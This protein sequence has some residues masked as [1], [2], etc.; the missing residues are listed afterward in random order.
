MSRRNPRPLV[1]RVVEAAEAALA[2]QKYASALDM[3]WLDP[4]AVDRWRQGRMDCLE[5]AIQTN[6]SRISE[7]LRLFR[8]WAADKGLIARE[9]PY[10]ARTP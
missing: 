1:G 10:V 3:L 9:T 5:E 7:A 4:G 6:P 2:A 8:A